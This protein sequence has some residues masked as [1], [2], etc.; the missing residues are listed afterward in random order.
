MQTGSSKRTFAD[1]H[2]PCRRWL[3]K[4]YDLDALDVVLNA[5]AV[6]RL[7]GDVTRAYESAARTLPAC[8]FPAGERGPDDAHNNAYPSAASLKRHSRPPH[9]MTGASRGATRVHAGAA[10]STFRLS[11]ASI[12]ACMI[13]TTGG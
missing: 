4:G 6:E 8:P 12:R 3:G 13:Q 5:A 2:G 10:C 9:R 11:T 1:A 7:D